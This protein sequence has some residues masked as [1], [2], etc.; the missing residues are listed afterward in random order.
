MGMDMGGRTMSTGLWFF[1]LG[2]YPPSPAEPDALGG[3]GGVLLGVAFL[4]LM[5]GG[6]V[7]C[8]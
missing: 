1:G 8:L 5:C 7:F 2:R 6:L 3:R 4:F